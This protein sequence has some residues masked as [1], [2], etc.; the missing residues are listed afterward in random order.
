MKIIRHTAFAVAFAALTAVTLPVF[1]QEDLSIQEREALELAVDMIEG[2]ERMVGKNINAVCS[3]LVQLLNESHK[4]PELKALLGEYAQLNLK[5]LKF[6]Q[7]PGKVKEI[8]DR[9]NDLKNRGK[10]PQSLVDAV[11]QVNRALLL[12]RL[13]DM[14]S[15]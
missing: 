5:S 8:I 14:L 10:L 3:E 2:S 13:H 6:Y 15:A 1:A 7:R 12:K 4:W 11:N 9:L